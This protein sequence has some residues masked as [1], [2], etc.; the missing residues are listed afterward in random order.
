VVVLLVVAAVWPTAVSAS[1]AAT[2]L[3]DVTFAVRNQNRSRVDCPADGRAYDVHGTLALP[4]AAVP[5]GVTLYLPGTGNGRSWHFTAVAGHDHIAAMARHGHASVSID[6]IA[7]GRSGIPDG[8]EVCSA[9]Q[10]DV[11]AQVAGELRTGSYV[12]RSDAVRAPV[13]ERVGLVGH[14]Q[15]HVVEVAAFDF[16][17]AFDAFGIVGWSQSVPRPPAAIV[18][19]AIALHA[20]RCQVEAEPKRP[21]AAGGYD[22]AFGRLTDRETVDPAVIEALFYDADAAVRRAYASALEREPCGIAESL[23]KEITASATALADVTR[24]VLIVVGDHDLFAVPQLYALRFSGSADVETA[25]IRRAGHMVMLE[26]AAPRFRRT[27]AAWLSARG[28]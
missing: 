16:G 26:R 27:L 24:P 15:G 3:L 5:S 25:V 10:A 8:H 14:S 1:V 12:L 19:S 11:A 9:S 17:D 21:G 6:P 18:S 2:R 4:A 20:T 22:L 23:S 7:F 13:F 28:L